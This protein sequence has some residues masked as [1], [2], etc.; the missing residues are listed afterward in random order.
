M[1]RKKVIRIYREPAGG[2]G[3]L[4]ATGEALALQGVAVFGAKTLLHMNQPEG[5][6]CPGCAWPALAADKPRVLDNE[7]IEGHTHRIDA[8][9]EELRNTRWDAIEHP[10]GIMRAV[11]LPQWD[12]HHAH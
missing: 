2:W 12:G 5:F 9:P 6:D 8:L 4:K 1:V 10:F 7:F 3:A 11:V